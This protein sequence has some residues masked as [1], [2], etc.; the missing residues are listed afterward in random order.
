VIQHINAGKLRA[1]AIT[2]EKRSARA[3]QRGPP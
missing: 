3:A 2:G 1:V